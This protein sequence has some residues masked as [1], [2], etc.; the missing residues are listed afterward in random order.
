MPR[1][2][3]V[4][5]KVAEDAEIRTE[6]KAIYKFFQYKTIIPKELSIEYFSSKFVDLDIGSIYSL[7]D[8]AF[9]IQ[10]YG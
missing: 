2:G 7:H 9:E 10:S 6:I 3:Y 5:S 8:I 4:M 1:Y